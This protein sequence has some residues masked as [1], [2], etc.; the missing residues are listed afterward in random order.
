[1]RQKL[2]Y[3]DYS[4]LIPYLILSTIGVIMVYSAS[5]DILLVNGFSPSVYMKRQIIYFVAAFLFFGIP[6]FALKLKIFKNRKFVMSYLGISFLMLFFLIVLKVISH[7]KAAI[8]GAVGWI[9]LGFINIQPVEVAKLSLVLY[10]AFVLSRRDGK[11]VPGQIWHNLFGPTVISFMMIGLVILEP[12]FGG[13]A[14]LFMI[15]F[16]MYSVSGIPTKLA[17]YWLI[18]LFIGIVLLMLVLLVWTPGFIKDSYQF[19][20]LLAFVHPFKLEKTG[21]AQLVNSYYAIHNGGLFGGGLGNSMQKRGYL[22]EPYTDFILSITAEELGVIGAIVI[23]TLL[24]FLMWHIMEVGIHANSQF[25]ALVC[26]GVV[27]MIFT[28]TLFNVGAVL[29]LLPI[30]G[31]TLPFISYG[32]SS[33]IVLTAA[34]GLVLNISAA[35]KKAMI[36]SRSVL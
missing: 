15:V 2:R 35:E 20:R 7:G 26:F 28:E 19:Q 10:L 16:V 13:S 22:P 30:T 29:G 3:L 14:I 11:F 18:G 27:T 17:V 9:N 36:E 34:L 12:D 1:M 32:G 24:F 23:I 25:N 8:N 6:C 5:S 21:G 4:I 31:V 33:M